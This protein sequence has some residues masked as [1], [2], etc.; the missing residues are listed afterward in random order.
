MLSRLLSR[1]CKRFG[2]DLSKRFVKEQRSRITIWYHV[3]FSNESNSEIIKMNWTRLHKGVEFENY[4]HEV[5]L[6]CSICSIPKV[7]LSAL[8]TF[9]CLICSISI[10]RLSTLSTLSISQ[11][12]DSGVFPGTSWRARNI[13]LLSSSLFTL[14]LFELM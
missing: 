8:S 3:C 7:R 13:S 11:V 12:L 2:F 1:Y 9:R 6:R 5:T 4:I 10:V 14:Y